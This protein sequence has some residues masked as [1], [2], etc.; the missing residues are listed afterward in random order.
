M[1]RLSYMNPGATGL[2]GAGGTPAPQDGAMAELEALLASLETSP[3]QAPP[4][5][6]QASTALGTIGDS[7]LAVSRVLSGGQ[8]PDMGPFQATQ[9]ARREA[10]ENENREVAAAGRDLRNRIRI[11]T[12]QDKRG[13]QAEIRKEKRIR[14]QEMNDEQLGF[15]RDRL[16]ENQRVE[17]DVRKSMLDQIIEL[18]IDTKGKDLLTTPTS[19]L[20]DILDAHDPGVAFNAIVRSL[21]SDMN[22]SKVHIDKAGK[23][24][25]DFERKG[26]GGANKDLPVGIIQTLI[27]AGEDPSSFI[28]DPVLGAAARKAAEANKTKLLN[29]QAD[30]FLEDVARVASQGVVTPTGEVDVL[31]QS[32]AS[33]ATDLRVMGKSEMSPDDLATYLDEQT[34]IVAENVTNQAPGWTEQTGTQYLVQLRQLIKVRFGDKPLEIYEDRQPGTSKSIFTKQDVERVAPRRR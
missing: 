12:F 8:A 19:E 16:M 23:L 33:A 13:E 6:G 31:N 3:Q 26:Q 20:K 1:A 28:E 18:G 10:F 21:P 29:T 25:Y 24:S 27:Q 32:I 14:V 22:I 15:H 30:S 17:N 2:G 11:G 5:T 7:L 34:Q 4:R 9:L